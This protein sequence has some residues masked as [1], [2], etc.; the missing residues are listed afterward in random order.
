[1]AGGKAQGCFPYT[2]INSAQ[3]N[4]TGNCT[5]SFNDLGARV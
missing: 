5:M 2:A 4:G 3:A 1:M